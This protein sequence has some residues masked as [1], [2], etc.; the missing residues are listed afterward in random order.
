MSNLHRNYGMVGSVITIAFFFPL[1]F[2][3]FYFLCNADV[4]DK[5]KHRL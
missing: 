2:F 5:G 1:K 4:P 3:Y